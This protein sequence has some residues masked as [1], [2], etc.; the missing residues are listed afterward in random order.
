MTSIFDQ[1]NEDYPPS[2]VDGINI[3]EIVRII[4]ISFER[5]EYVYIYVTFLTSILVKSGLHE[6]RIRHSNISKNQEKRCVRRQSHSRMYCQQVPHC[7]D[8]QQ[9]WEITQDQFEDWHPGRNYV[10]KVHEWM[11]PDQHILG[12][13]WKS[14]AINFCG[15][16]SE[17]RSRVTL[18]IEEVGK[19]KEHN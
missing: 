15:K 9:W 12:S 5:G 13:N 19:I 6:G 11:S 1:F 2:K 10:V 3:E 4:Y 14:C 8:A 16:D 17:R 18:L 7:G